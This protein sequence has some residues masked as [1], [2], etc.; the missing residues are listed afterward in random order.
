MTVMKL[1]AD[2][3]HLER[4]ERNG[5][6]QVNYL[7]LALTRRCNLNCASCYHGAPNEQQDMSI[8]TL[9]KAFDLAIAGSG[10]LHVQLTGGEPTLVP[11]LI[12]A[13]AQRAL[14]VPRSCTMGIQTNGTCLNMQMIALLKRYQ[15]QVGVSLD[16]PPAIQEEVRGKSAET[17]RGLQLLESCGLPFRVT[18]VVSDRNVADLERLAWLLAGFR[19]ALGLGLD[20]LVVKGKARETATLFPATSAA[21][22]Q[23]VSSLVKTLNIINQRK[24]IPLQLRELELVKRVLN[25]NK[26]QAHPTRN[27][28]FAQQGTSLAVHPDG[29]LFPCG[30]SLGDPRLLA[31]SV[32][33][34]APMPLFPQQTLTELVADCRSCPLENNCPGDCPSRLHYNRDYN[35]LLACDLYRT[36]AYSFLN[37]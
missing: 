2:P 29:R 7:I 6:T 15:I 18:T 28:C 19:Q 34:T 21:L 22:I 26:R 10:P 36:L 16:G 14:T 30:Q 31:G 33:Q 35:P 12:E 11:E 24:E 4:V 1:N 8:A 3:A 37:P 20:L 17:L 32:D 9:D 5:Q 27:F 25:S 23:G 13:A